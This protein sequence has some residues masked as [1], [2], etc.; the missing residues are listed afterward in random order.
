MGKCK[1]IVGK[2]SG[3][4]IGVLVALILFC[5]S[6]FI[7]NQEGGSFIDMALLEICIILSFWI[8]IVVIY[9]SKGT[10]FFLNDFSRENR[11][12]HY[13]ALTMV[14]I[15]L[16]IF[17]PYGHIQVV[18][19]LPNDDAITR[20]YF[21]GMTWVWRL[22]DTHNSVEWYSI[23]YFWYYTLKMIAVG[24]FWIITDYSKKLHEAQKQNNSR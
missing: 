21:V 7:L 2:F 5:L 10:F 19:Y 1:S 20:D 3:G 13:F 12:M 14:L 24:V 4:L 8:S 9:W 16:A 11:K 23:W 15:F 6:R 17:V 22:R 18:D